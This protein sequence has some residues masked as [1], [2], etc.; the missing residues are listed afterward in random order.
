M[1][2][3]FVMSAN[4]NCIKRAKIKLGYIAKI[5]LLDVIEVA[6]CALATSLKSLAD[7]V[8]QTPMIHLIKPSL[9]LILLV[10]FG[11]SLRSIGADMVLMWKGNLSVAYQLA[12]FRPDLGF[13]SSL[14]YMQAVD[15]ND[16][17][18]E[19]TRSL[20]KN[21]PYYFDAI[22]N[23][24]ICYAQTQRTETARLYWQEILRYWPYHASARENLGKLNESHLTKPR[25]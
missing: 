8:E 11:F 21:Y 1:V 4:G 14:A 18:I 20:L 19:T 22:N 13:L 2:L 3:S 24:A 12:P 9:C 25:P 15:C 7:G 10:A 5:T 6:L 16:K 23:L 17:A